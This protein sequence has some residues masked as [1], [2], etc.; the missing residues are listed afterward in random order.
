MCVQD[1]D[2]SLFGW[3]GLGGRSTV[4]GVAP[5]AAAARPTY[6]QGTPIAD[7]PCP[8][9]NDPVAT[10]GYTCVPG[11]SSVAAGTVVPADGLWGDPQ[12]LVIE[13]RDKVG[14]HLSFHSQMCGDRD[15][16]CHFVY[17]HTY[18]CTALTI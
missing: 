11:W 9:I 1:L 2:G 13:S 10:P 6:A 12:L 3:M 15:G 17:T 5:V 8:F 14:H 16:F 18:P 4:V 7:G